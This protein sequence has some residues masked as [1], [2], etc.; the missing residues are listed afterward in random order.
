MDNDL[1]LEHYEKYFSLLKKVFDSSKIEQM[2]DALGER[3]AVCPLS[4][5]EEKGGKPGRMIE[6]SLQVAQKAKSLAS[7]D[8]AMSAV[9]VCLVHELG[10]IGDLEHEMYIHQDSDWHREKLGQT[11][12]FNENC[13]RMNVGHRTLYL[14]QHFGISLTQEEWTAILVSQ[15]LHLEESRYYGNQKQ[16][17]SSVVQ[18]ART[19]VS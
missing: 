16:L 11:Y 3:M 18:Y 17:L 8:I 10:R 1:I 5:L 15:G 4:H 2:F 13:A 9:K 6:F 12:K 14:L 7:K 19:C